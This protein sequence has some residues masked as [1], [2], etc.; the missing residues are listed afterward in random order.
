MSE[1]A[2]DQSPL[3]PEPGSDGEP[4]HETSESEHSPSERASSDEKDSTAI[5][6][7]PYGDVAILTLSGDDLLSLG[8]NPERVDQVQ[9][10]TYNGAVL[11]EPVEN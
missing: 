6:K 11:I 9:Y 2:T 4:D 3:K 10:R 8:I 5:H 7:G 1:A